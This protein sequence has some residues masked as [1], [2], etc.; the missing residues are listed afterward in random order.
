M[1]SGTASAVLA[2]LKTKA[3]AAVLAGTVV[4]GG[5]AT[6]VAVTTGAIQLPGHSTVSAQDG[7]KDQSD[8]RKQACAKNG[9][10]TQLAGDY[11]S[12]FGGDQTAA[13]D[14]ICQIFVDNG[15]HAVGFGKIR[16][17]LNLA[18]WIESK[19]GSTACLTAAPTN[20]NSSSD[21]GQPTG[22]PGS[23][24]DHGKPTSTPGSS[25]DH[26]KPADPGKPTST[27]GQQSSGEQSALTIPSASAATTKSVLKAIFN[28]EKAGTSIAKQARAC[29]AP[30]SVS[31]AG[32]DSTDQGKSGSATPEATE[33]ETSTP[34]AHS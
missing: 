18:A 11:K 17:A 4:V 33:A 13:R 10:A 21:H 34:E 25:G 23:S 20:G 9:D 31:D 16:Q 19:G 32:S 22:T 30:H 6:A 8:D 12:M 5:G 27:P 1:A 24:D 29:N 26:G 14:A 15:E 2:A 28:A 3:A 7:T